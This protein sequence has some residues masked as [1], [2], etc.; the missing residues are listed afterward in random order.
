MSNIYIV[1][2]IHGCCKTFKYLVREEIRLKKADVLYCLGDYID[3]GPD[4]KGVIDYIMDLRKDGFDVRT[5][6]GNHEQML[7]D[8]YGSIDSFGFW[9]GNGGD[10]TLMSFEIDSIFQLGARYLNFFQQTELYVATKDFILAHAGLNFRAAD[11]LKDEA[12]MLWIR[13]FKVDRNYL[14]KRVLIHGHTPVTGNFIRSQKLEGAVNLD[15]G[16]V[17][18]NHEELGSLFALNFT[19]GKFSEVKNID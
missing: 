12:S 10:E 18:K 9:A 3:R 11:P 7:M 17:Y 19:T 4:S 2:D 13:G 5:L 16:C 14:G 15:G 8:S 1:G 6:R